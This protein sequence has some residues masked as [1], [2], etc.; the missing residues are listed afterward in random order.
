MLENHTPRQRVKA[1]SLVPKA[2]LPEPVRRTDLN[3][4]LGMKDLQ[5]QIW[6]NSRDVEPAWMHSQPWVPA[7]H[8][9][10]RG[11]SMQASLSAFPTHTSQQKVLPPPVAI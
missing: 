8:S 2:D 9:P 6:I 3:S 1:K 5:D 4:I 7:W 11:F 10:S